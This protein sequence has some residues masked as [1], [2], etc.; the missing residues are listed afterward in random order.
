MT[1]QMQTEPRS[2]STLA[3]IATGVA[4]GSVDRA[5]QPAV[6]CAGFVP[7]LLVNKPEVAV[8][9]YRYAVM[10]PLALYL[11]LR[12][13]TVLAVWH[14]PGARLFV[15]FAAYSLLTMLWSVNG[16]DAAPLASDMLAT[17]TLFSRCFAAHTSSAGLALAGEGF[18]RRRHRGALRSRI[19][20]ASG[21][22][23]IFNLNRGYGS[24][25]YH[26]TVSWL[27]GSLCLLLLS[28]Q[29]RLSPLALVLFCG[30]FATTIFSHSRGGFIAFCTGYVVM[31]FRQEKPRREK[32]VIAGM[33][34]TIALIYAF[35]P[36][37][38]KKFIDKGSDLRPEIWE[39]GY[40]KMTRTAS[41][42]WF[43]N[44][45]NCTDGFQIKTF[46]IQQYHSLY[47][48]QLFHGG[49]AG[50]ALYLALLFVVL[51]EGW[52]Y[53]DRDEP[54]VL[55]ADRHVR[56][57]HGVWRPVLCS[58]VGVF[59]LFPASLVDDTFA[60]LPREPARS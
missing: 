56:S 40:E 57:A 30:G 44:G 3:H 26:V 58:A 20:A 47:W 31:L 38:L 53:A 18:S 11:C 32:Q 12:P 19:F 1:L 6:C 15:V 34:V 59:H 49:I 29:S 27:A 52:R 33:L 16:T 51:R 50:L 45:I 17:A 23:E 13:S 9:L 2:R 28:R 7:G 55:Y 24:F 54:V 35:L 4:R 22:V 60:R 5:S 37:H 8:D 41:T 43:G 25:N 14:V 48:S 10:L 42:L 39:H 21:Q 46:F 36:F